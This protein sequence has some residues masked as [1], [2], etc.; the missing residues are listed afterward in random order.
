MAHHL[1]NKSCMEY[2]QICELQKRV[3]AECL[4]S[5]AVE[6]EFAVDS[7]FCLFLEASKDF[8]FRLCQSLS[9]S[10]RGNAV[11]LVSGTCSRSSF[12]ASSPW[13]HYSVEVSEPS[14]VYVALYIPCC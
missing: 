9:G 6:F 13:E 5:C 11:N 3:S 2:E 1:C 10:T 4:A 14:L 7:H 12:L 8:L